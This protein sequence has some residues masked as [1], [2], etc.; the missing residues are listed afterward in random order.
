MK[1]DILEH[2][3]HFWWMNNAVF[4]LFYFPNLL[5]S[6]GSAGGLKLKEGEMSPDFK[7]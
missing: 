1:F 3:E 6:A 4:M 7:H 2:S 5:G